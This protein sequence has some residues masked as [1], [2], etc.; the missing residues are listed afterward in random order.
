MSPAFGADDYE[1]GKRHGLAFLQP[2][3]ARGEFPASMPI[4]GGLFVKDADPLLIEELKR[5]G[6][7]WKAGRITH[8]YPHCWRCGTPLLYYART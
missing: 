8:Q 1:A 5:R 4:V 7:L 2:V 3:G 6:V